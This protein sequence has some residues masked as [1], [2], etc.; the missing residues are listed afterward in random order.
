M[1]REVSDWFRD[2]DWQGQTHFIV[3]YCFYYAEQDVVVTDDTE[4]Q[5]KAFSKL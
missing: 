1:Q 3:I 4:E 2:A 5:I